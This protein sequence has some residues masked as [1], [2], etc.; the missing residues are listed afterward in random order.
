MKI[1]E[2]SGITYTFLWS[3][4]FMQ[5]LVNYY[6]YNIESQNAIFLPARDGKV[7]SFVDV[8]DIAAVAAKVLLPENDSRGNQHENKTYVI[9]GPEALSYSQAAEIISN[10]IGR[11]ISYIDT[12]EE[13]VRKA[14]KSVG[15]EDWLIDAILEEFYTTRVGNRSETTNSIELILG[16]KPISFAQFVRD[17]ANSFN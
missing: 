13:D 9:T 16:R 4:A 3:S 12:S 2:E 14:M 5:N 7:S 6:G 1:I 11:K 15:R 10:Q 8:R 17:Y